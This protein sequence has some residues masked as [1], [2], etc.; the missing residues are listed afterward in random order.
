M[1]FNYPDFLNP[2]SSSIDGNPSNVNQNSSNINQ[3]L[4]KINQDLSNFNLSWK[5]SSQDSFRNS[6]NLPI[7]LQGGLNTITSRR[8][9]YAAEF[10]PRESNNFNLNSIE[11]RRPSGIDDSGISIEPKL[12]F[13][14]RRL[15]QPRNQFQNSFQPIQFQ[16]QFQS[17]YQNQPNS[18]NSLNSINSIN[19][20]NSMNPMNSPHPSHAPPP[21]S[22]PHHSQHL[23]HPPLPHPS[24]SSSSS[25]SL[26]Q[27][28][29]GL[30]LKDQY[31]IVSPDLKNL[32]M[33]TINYF[34][35][36]SITFKIINK[37]NALLLKPPILKLITFIKN[38]NNLTFNHKVLC[39]V[40]NKNGKFDLLSY[41]NNSNIYLQKNDLVIVDG[42]RGKDLV[43]IVEPL[44]SLNFAILF[45]FLKKIEHLKSL[46]I[47]GQSNR[48]SVG[49]IG[50]HLTNLKASSII[51]SHSNE[52]NEF[53]ITLPT[54]QV[55]RFAT[56]KEVHKILGK[57]LE[58]KK[59]FITCFNKIKELNLQSDLTLINVEYQSDFKKLI[60]YY[61]AGFRRIDFRLLI[62]ELFKIYKTRIWLCAVLPLDQPKL[63]CNTNPDEKIE[64]K[65]LKKSTTT[66]SPSSSSTSSIPQ[67]YELSNDQIVN[68]SIN[69]FDNL[70]K[71]NYFHS[72]NLLNLLN[73]LELD[74][75]G[76][77]YGFNNTE[78]CAGQG[79]IPKD[80]IGS[81]FNPFG[82]N[83]L[84]KQNF[85]L[86]R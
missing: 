50:T 6:F 60:F 84:F 15:S 23:S 75:K 86:T 65:S 7:E 39:L 83:D 13:I 29:N 37:I 42:D 5:K 33:K 34:Q 74:I 3:D 57:F 46:T 25:S 64:E 19:Q 82:D 48:N 12:D 22:A 69:E 66:S 68:F 53:I 26:I 38:L 35:D 52:D 67:E 31:I 10:K 2:G 62:K 49:S 77:F 1:N 72:I 41:P 17:Q 56:P 71:S 27:L 11:E 40:V 8:P 21:H 14:D 9:S 18:I 70:S 43:M 76:H 54:K 63:Y 28:E 55:L 24:A 58:E 4:S 79:N 16:N 73:H 20:M 32:Y 30:I 80:I 61:F 45:N 51:N 59:A 81:N 85:Q 44:I 36:S 78:N 47:I